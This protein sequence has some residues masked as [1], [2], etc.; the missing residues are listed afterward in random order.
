MST[1]ISTDWLVAPPSVLFEGPGFARMI[2]ALR[3][4]QNQVAAAL[5]TPALV[6]D[7]T[8]QFERLAAA[9]GAAQVPEAQRVFGRR[10]DL[11]GR[12][13]AL[14]P[15]ARL[16]VADAQH[17]IAWVNFGPLYLGSGGA[18]HGGAIPLL[19]DEMMGKLS[20]VGGRTHARTAYLHVDY[21]AL[22]PVG[23]ELRVSARVDREEGRKRYLS[24][25]LHHGEK[26][27]A[28]AEGLFVGARS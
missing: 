24:G 23:E 19:F 6:A 11:P 22:T 25:A 20:N 7:A 3:A 16:E 5:P 12:G 9:F 21:R 14:V 2:E 27:L 4:L 26:L 28:E 15:P 10:K 8:E 17:V 1:R 18:V 13:Q